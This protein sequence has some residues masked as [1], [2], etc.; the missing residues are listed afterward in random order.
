MH[1]KSHARDGA[2][3]CRRPWPPMTSPL[4]TSAAAFHY[5]RKATLGVAGVNGVEGCG[6]DG[7]LGWMIGLYWIKG[8]T[9]NDDQGQDGLS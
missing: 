9:I 3:M 6:R 7:S 1:K 2:S 4:T 8:L 5:G